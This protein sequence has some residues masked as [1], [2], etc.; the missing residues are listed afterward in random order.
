MYIQSA[1]LKFHSI[2]VYSVGQQSVKRTSCAPDDSG[3]VMQFLI[4]RPTQPAV[5]WILGVLSLEVTQ[6]GYEAD[7]SSPSSA[8]V[9]HECRYT[10]TPPRLH[11]T[12][13][14]SITQ[15]NTS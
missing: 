10:S 9:K 1:R 5:Q 7:N 2:H 6:L 3:N 12:H 4:L 13:T 15:H 11:G 8:K 14:D